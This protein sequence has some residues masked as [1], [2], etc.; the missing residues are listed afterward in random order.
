[1]S[2]IS[3]PLDIFNRNAFLDPVGASGKLDSNT[4]ET[5]SWRGRSDPPKEPFFFDDQRDGFA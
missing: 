3:E 5:V 2:I 4:S 1:V